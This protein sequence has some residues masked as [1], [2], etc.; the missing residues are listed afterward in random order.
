[1]ADPIADSTPYEQRLRI[2]DRQF[3]DQWERLTRYQ[4]LNIRNIF[5][6]AVRLMEVPPE[7]DDI[8]DPLPPRRAL[9]VAKRYKGGTLPTVF[10]F[11]G[12]EGDALAQAIRA[13]EKKA[14]SLQAIAPPVAQEVA[15]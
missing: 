12:I 11:T 9:T 6:Y 14:I 4:R 2:I 13:M 1:M 8:A 5:G 15:R 7:H 3:G 10:N